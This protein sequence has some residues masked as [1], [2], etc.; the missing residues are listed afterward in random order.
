MVVAPSQPNVD[1][2]ADFEVASLAGFEV[3]SLAG[4]DGR[5]YW[6][7]FVRTTYLSGVISEIGI[8]VLTRILSYSKSYFMDDCSYFLSAF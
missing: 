5:T 1:S 6:K 7:N 2:P 4:S 8:F 3:A